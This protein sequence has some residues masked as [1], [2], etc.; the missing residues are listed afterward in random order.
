METTMI[1]PQTL[2]LNMELRF[3]YAVQCLIAVA[4]ALIVGAVLFATDA[5]AASMRVKAACASDYFAHCSK[6]S[7]SSPQ[8]R[9]CMR[10]IG[11]GLSKRCVNALV[12]DGEVSN[13][14]VAAH[15]P[16]RRD[17]DE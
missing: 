6:Y 16:K 15:T 11:E 3:V 8:T 12:A 17:D 4:A 10:G 5:S 13:D 1:R 7:P 2:N 14:E 9:D